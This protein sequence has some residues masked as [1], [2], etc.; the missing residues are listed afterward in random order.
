MTE[1]NAL[2]HT[3]GNENQQIEATVKKEGRRLFSFIRKRISTDEEAED[4]LQDVFY[5]LVQSYRMMKPVGQVATWLFTVARNKITD[6]YRK[7]KTLS[8]EDVFSGVTSDGEERL[9]LEDLLA[10]GDVS[11]EDR[12]FFDATMDLIMAALDEIPVNQKE[13]FIMHE[14]EGKSLQDISDLMGIPVKTVIS[15]KRYAVLYLRNKLRDTYDELG[16]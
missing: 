8:T 2:T 5:E 1:N 12:M 6:R 7:S 4:I 3:V 13:A 9:F 10:M 16:Q 14:M 15:R 11:A